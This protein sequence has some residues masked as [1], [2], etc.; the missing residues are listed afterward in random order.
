MSISSWVENRGRPPC[1][2]MSGLDYGEANAAIY[3]QVYPRIPIEQVYAMARLARHGSAL[4]LGVGTGRCAIPLAV[5]GV[6][7]TGMDNSRKMLSRCRTKLRA[8]GQPSL[9]LVQADLRA[10][11]FARQFALAYALVDT[12]SLLPDRTAQQ[13][14][15]VEVAQVLQPGGCFL[16]EGSTI[17]DVD[18]QSQPVHTTV[19]WPGSGGA[20]YQLWHL[21]L[22]PDL[23]D[24]YAGVA[25]LERVARWSD[26]A[27]T[28]WRGG[29]QRMISLY[30]IS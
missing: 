20:A 9:K 1:P 17:E 12:L 7:V 22:G 18:E 11:P 14:A 5:A 28:L 21:P 23:L 27:A 8:A 2:D 25:G 29:Q 4:E 30:R 16:H 24:Q 6:D 26:W 3:D 10:L 19:P 15:L 13:Q